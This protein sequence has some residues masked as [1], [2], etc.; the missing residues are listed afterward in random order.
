MKSK[1]IAIT[2]LLTIFS[3]LFNN[4]NLEDNSAISPLTQAQQDTV[5]AA[6]QAYIAGFPLVIMELTKNQFIN[7]EI[8]VNQFALK[9][10]FVSASDTSVVRPNVD[11]YYSIA[12][13]D[14]TKGAQI[15]EMPSTI[16]NGKTYYYMMPMLDAYTN[17]F[18]S[19]GTRTGYTNAGN[20]LIIGPNDSN[21]K[22]YEHDPTIDG[23]FQAPTNLVW[24][25]GRFEVDNSNDAKVVSQLQKEFDIWSY[26]QHI[27]PT[28][29]TPIKNVLKY[30]GNMPNPN[31]LIQKMPI[32]VF[33]NQMAGLLADNP[34]TPNDAAINNDLKMIGVAKNQSFDLE[35]FSEPVKN[36]LE[37][38]PQEVLSMINTYYTKGNGNKDWTVNLDSLMGKYGTD[39]FL[40][41]VIAYEGLG[42]NRIEDAVYYA[43][44]YDDNQEPLTGDNNYTLTFPK[45]KLPP[46]NVD[47]FW[48]LTMYLS[49][50][51]LYDNTES[52]YALGHNTD[53]PFQYNADSSLTLYIQN[54]PPND[55]FT[56]NW[57]PAPRDSFNVLLRAYYPD[58]AILDSTWTPPTFVIQE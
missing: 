4:C 12:F 53:R 5:K 34:L 58:D 56:N 49:N 21:L 39:Y 47:G 9:Q 15:L 40:R 28:P 55:S 50:G 54:Q 14:L 32:G 27:S 41:A 30:T 31:Q 46:V 17:V 48:S 19:P 52:V 43:N 1:L 44:T 13:L 45:G 24:I 10:N 11:T 20:Y 57:L 25:L 2:V 42:A 38:I 7:P 37:L 22:E 3:M 29:K 16:I 23:I 51:N 33:F 36:R 26:E 18:I 8:P 35:S 6:T